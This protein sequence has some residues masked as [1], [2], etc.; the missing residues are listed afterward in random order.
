MTAGEMTVGSGNRAANA[1]G[2]NTNRATR[3]L[4]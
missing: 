4:D 1:C 3:G 2:K